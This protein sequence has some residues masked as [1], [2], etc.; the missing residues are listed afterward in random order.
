MPLQSLAVFFF[1]FFFFLFCL[2]VFVADYEK[3]L[4]SALKSPPQALQG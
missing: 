1:F 3:F 4:I 2:C